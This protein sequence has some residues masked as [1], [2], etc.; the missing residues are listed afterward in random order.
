M[1]M[2]LKTLLALT[3][4]G[5]ATFRQILKDYSK[6]FNNS[7]SAFL[8]RKNTYSPK[9]ESIDDPKL[10]D[11]VRVVTTVD[12]KM[13]YFFQIVGPYI[14]NV[15]AQEATNAT[16][17]VKAN[18]FVEGQDWGEFS[19]LELLR[20]KGIVENGDLKKMIED[21]PVRSDAEIWT[22]TTTE[23][24]AGRTI[25]EKPV[26]FAQNKTTQKEQYI[27]V[28]PNI[29]KLKSSEGYKPQLASKDTILILGDQTR[30]EFS[31]MW[32]HRQRAEVLRKLSVLRDAITV[33]L[34]KANDVEIVESNMN[35]DKL[36]NYLFK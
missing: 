9:D 16:G 28:D 21:I 26:V 35:G 34:E 24:Y 19:A 10:R 17:K 15:F 25:F 6:F 23:E 5:L 3:Q 33:A 32:S 11:Y 22:L 31:G 18:L 2:K 4:D 1:K 12:E 20:L 30:Q 29:D 36:L 13:E 7:Q 27:L 8:G 14:T